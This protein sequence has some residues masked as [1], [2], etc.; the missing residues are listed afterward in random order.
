M[1]KSASRNV[2]TAQQVLEGL[3]RLA[4]FDL[5]GLYDT[6]GNLKP[7]NEWPEGYSKLVGGIE[8]KVEFDAEQA[9][10]ARVTRLKTT[11]R[12]KAFELLARHHKLLT[13]RIEIT[14]TT[15]FSER[16]RKARERRLKDSK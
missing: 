2:L 9:Q 13:D 10:I 7:I 1:D 8:T 3:T 14:D 15:G 4:T 6:Q 11:P 12:E 5:S 16:L